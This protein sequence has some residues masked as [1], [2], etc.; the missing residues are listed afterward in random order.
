VS[1]DFKSNGCND[2]KPKPEAVSLKGATRTKCRNED[3]AKRNVVKAA[4]DPTCVSAQG[5]AAANCLR[6]L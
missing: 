6:T 1:E 5:A 2:G 3:A 4:A